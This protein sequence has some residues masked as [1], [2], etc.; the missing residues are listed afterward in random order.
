MEITDKKIIETYYEGFN[1]ELSMGGI[2]DSSKYEKYPTLKKAYSV[3]GHDAIVGD[4]VMSHDCQTEEQILKRI[5][6]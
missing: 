3:G 4:D 2:F 5:K 6:K 1:D